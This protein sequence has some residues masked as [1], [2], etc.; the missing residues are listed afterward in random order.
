MIFKLAITFFS[1]LERSTNFQISI[2]MS[3]RSYHI[4]KKFRLSPALFLI[5]LSK[6]DIFSP[7]NLS[8][9]SIF[10]TQTTSN[11]LL[12]ILG[13]CIA[14]KVC[15]N[16]KKWKKCLLISEPIASTVHG[17]H[18]RFSYRKQPYKNTMKGEHKG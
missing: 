4:N 12:L 9:S 1:E 10:H 11:Q 5:L 2:H 15:I 3:I 17:V 16:V 14:L 13:S 7:K 6:S 18:T 8:F